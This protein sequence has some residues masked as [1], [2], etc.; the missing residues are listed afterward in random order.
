MVGDRALDVRAAQ[1]HSVDSA[2]VGWGYAP[3]GELDE[4]G[5]T[6]RVG[7]VDALRTLLH[8]R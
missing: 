3:P 1:A 2:V 7:D 4:C 5:A 6:F 8:P